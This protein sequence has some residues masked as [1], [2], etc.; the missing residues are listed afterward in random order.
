MKVSPAQ[1]AADGCSG[2]GLS[3][4]YPI[5]AYYRNNRFP[6]VTP[7]GILVHQTSAGYAAVASAYANSA[8]CARTLQA[9]AGQRVRLRFASFD[10]VRDALDQG[11]G[12]DFD[13]AD[14]GFPIYNRPHP[15]T[16]TAIP[17]W[18]WGHRDFTVSAWFRG[19][20]WTEDGTPAESGRCGLVSSALI[21]CG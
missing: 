2:P 6:R 15:L 10:T 8:N 7:A 3:L 12:L 13:A 20:L 21:P 11:D 14:V 17:E 5:P 9:P 16:G 4:L 18:G 19:P 1:C